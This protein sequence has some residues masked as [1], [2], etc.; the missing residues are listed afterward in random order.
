MP[1]YSVIEAVR[2]LEDFSAGSDVH[3]EAIRFLASLDECD[4]AKSLVR[5][6]Q[7]EDLGVRWEAGNLLAR[8]GQKA[9]PILLK[10]LAAKIDDDVQKLLIERYDYTR[11][12]LESACEPLE[13]LVNELLKEE[14]VQ[15]EDLERIL[16]P[17]AAVV[18]S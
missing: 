5:A 7:S 10:A 14:T 17:K 3:L 11:K 8:M 18:R 12:L 1:F 16:G 2:A 6:L 13:R 15:Q 9:I 4:E